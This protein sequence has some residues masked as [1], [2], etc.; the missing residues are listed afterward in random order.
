MVTFSVL[1]FSVFRRKMLR[2][3]AFALPKT[4]I[5]ET[6]TGY[7]S[8]RYTSST[9]NCKTQ[10]PNSTMWSRGLKTQLFEYK[11]YFFNSKSELELNFYIIFRIVNFC[12]LLKLSTAHQMGFYLRLTFDKYV[13]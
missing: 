11:L 10:T 7:P 3:D 9:T 2:S 5:S 12:Y 6:P 1:R 4:N 13:M 8:S